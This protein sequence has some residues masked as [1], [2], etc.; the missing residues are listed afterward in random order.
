MAQG[1]DWGSLGTEQMGVQAPPELL[2]V[3]VNIPFAVPAEILKAL[4]TSTPPPGLSADESYAFKRLDFFFKHGLAYALEMAERPQ[5]LYAIADSPVGLAAWFLDHDLRSYE[6]IARSFDGQREG[7]TRDD[8]LDNVT[9]AWVTNTAISGRSSPSGEQASLLR[10]D[11]L[12]IP[13]AV[14]PFPDELY[15]V[16]RVGQS[17]R[18][19]K[20][21]LQQSPKGGQFPAWKQPQLF[22]ESSREFPVPALVRATGRATELGTRMAV[23][24]TA[25]TS[26]VDAS[27]TS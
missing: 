5:T 9:V 2:G 12:N 14:S 20:Y 15:Q 16:P 11:G 8:V 1:G 10:S 26:D 21:P 22:S 25:C 23:S 4:Q 3:H 7:L 27:G 18:I 17:L 24:Q 19:P 6:L 13:I